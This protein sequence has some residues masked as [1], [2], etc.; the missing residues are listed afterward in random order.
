MELVINKDVKCY[1]T[2]SNVTLDDGVIRTVRMGV[3]ARNRKEAYKI[4][5]LALSTKFKIWEIIDVKCNKSKIAKEHIL[6]F[7]EQQKDIIKEQYKHIAHYTYKGE[8]W[9]RIRKIFKY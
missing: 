1:K 7:E 2:E 8:R 5:T 9:E 4:L 6:T 3:Y